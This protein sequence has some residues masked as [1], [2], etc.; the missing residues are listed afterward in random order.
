MTEDKCTPS[1]NTT[2]LVHVRN[3]QYS[4]F[5]RKPKGDECHVRMFLRRGAFGQSGI[6]EN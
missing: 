6:C 1:N 2:W 4:N 3:A 5:N